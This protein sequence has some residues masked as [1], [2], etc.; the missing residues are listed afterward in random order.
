MLIEINLAVVVSHVNFELS[1]RAPP[2][3]AVVR[4]SHPEITLRRSVAHSPRRH[5]LHPQEAKEQSAKVSEN[6]DSALPGV[7][8]GNNVLLTA[9]AR[10]LSA[11]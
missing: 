5:E 4:I 7:K 6:G 11:L 2:L 8:N 9:D 3:P 10:H 1:R